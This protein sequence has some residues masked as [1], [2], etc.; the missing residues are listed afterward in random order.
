MLVSYSIATVDPIEFI[1]LSSSRFDDIISY[2]LIFHWANAELK[3]KQTT[4]RVLMTCV[5][6]TSWLTAGEGI[7]HWMRSSG[8]HQTHS[9]ML[10]L[11]CV[12]RAT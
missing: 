6:F 9:G 12:I 8:R 10:R 3:P 5:H 11:R 2:K 1:H 4:V 7:G